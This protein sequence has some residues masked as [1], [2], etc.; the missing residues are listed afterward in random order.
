MDEDRV[1]QAIFRVCEDP[2]I[3]YLPVQIA[4]FIRYGKVEP[5]TTESQ[6]D[7]Q[8]KYYS[9]CEP[10]RQLG[11]VRLTNYIIGY[12]LNLAEEKGLLVE[13]LSVIETPEV[14]DEQAPTGD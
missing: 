7:K 10:E 9:S 14:N 12:V 6:E 3:M 1:K 5:A 8:K 11:C 13:G 2:R 4:H